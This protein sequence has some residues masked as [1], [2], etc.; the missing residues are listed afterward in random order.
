MFFLTLLMAALAT[1][2]LSYAINLPG[3]KHFGRSAIR[4]MARC[5]R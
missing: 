4:P 1:I 5:S 3:R 2:P